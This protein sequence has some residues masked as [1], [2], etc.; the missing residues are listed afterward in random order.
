MQALD[1]NPNLIKN[2]KRLHSLDLYPN[3]LDCLQA[4][5]RIIVDTPALDE[6]WIEAGFDGTSPGDA[7]DDTWD[8]LSNKPGITTSTL[9]RHLRPFTS[10]STPM[11]LK[12]LALYKLNIRWVAQTYMRV[13]DFPHL[14]EL[15]VRS[16]AGADAI[17]AE[18]AKPAKRPTRLE[19]LTFVHAGDDRNPQYVQSA[20]DN[21]LTVVSSLRKLCV[22]YGDANVLPKIDGVCNQAAGLQ[23]LVVHS[24]D[25]NMLGQ[26][27]VYSKDDF[28]RLCRECTHL[29]QL[30]IACPPLKVLESGLGEPFKNYLVCLPLPPKLF[31]AY[32]ATP[33][34]RLFF[35]LPSCLI[36]FVTFFWCVFIFPMYSDILAS[37]VLMLF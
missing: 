20:L 14:T 32:P 8:D 33:L 5:H 4:C 29:Q 30:I 35:H 25:H 6:L 26:G 31:L 27:H 2:L 15:E 19:D 28:A 12:F 16:C 17:F 21:F 24:Y 9:F 37:C 13:I 7:S 10:C 11:R 34:P 36:F 1:R 3:N 22:V 23:H 18:M